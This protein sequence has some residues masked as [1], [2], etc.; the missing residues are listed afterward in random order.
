MR[1]FVERLYSHSFKHGL[2][3]LKLDEDAPFILSDPN[4]EK[5]KVSFGLI[6]CAFICTFVH[7][8]TFVY[9]TGLVVCLCVRFLHI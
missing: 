3:D 5:E 4:S 2:F 9:F 1:L 6:A 8:C 7:F